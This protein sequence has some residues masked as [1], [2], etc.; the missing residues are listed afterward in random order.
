MNL[1]QTIYMWAI[2][3]PLWCVV[4]VLFKIERNT[5][6]KRDEH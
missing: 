5:R 3:M 6:G 1:V 2:L 4:Y